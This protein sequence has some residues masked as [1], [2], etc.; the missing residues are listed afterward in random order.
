MMNDTRL[1]ALR[2]INAELVAHV[3]W[4]LERRDLDGLS[5]II[6]IVDKLTQLLIEIEKTEHRG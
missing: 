6:P 1:E 3:K 5:R 2:S 4:L